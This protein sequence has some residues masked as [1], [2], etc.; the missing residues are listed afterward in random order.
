MPLYSYKCQ[1]CANAFD[2][3]YSIA[4]MMVPTFSPCAE[5]GGEIRKVITSPMISYAGA[6]RT[7]SDVFNDRLKEMKRRY[8]DN[9]NTLSDHIKR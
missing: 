6:S 7:T 9:E 2:E 1:S 4:D 8:G 5:C 3:R